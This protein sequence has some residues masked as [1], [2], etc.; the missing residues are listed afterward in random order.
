MLEQGS[1]FRSNGRG[2]LRRA[3]I[4]GDGIVRLL[5][6]EIQSGEFDE[7]GGGSWKL[8]LP[9]DVKP[10]TTKRAPPGRRNFAERGGG[11][12]QKGAGRGVCI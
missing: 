10:G 12:S 4:E 5:W 6:I 11:G 9:P 8:P 1:I 3:R 7:I 2:A